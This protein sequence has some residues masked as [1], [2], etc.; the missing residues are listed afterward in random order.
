MGTS[1]DLE[2]E[3][4]PQL[5]DT[6]ADEIKD[7]PVSVKVPITIVTGM[8]E[9]SS[10]KPHMLTYPRISWSGQ[11]DA[12]EL[13]SHGGTRKEDSSYHEWY[14]QSLVDPFIAGANMSEEFGDCRFKSAF[15]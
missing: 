11:D 5:V 13:H 1:I 14:A 6:A 2:D 10:L 3:P 7:D 4:P 9:A 12:V 8:F 15:S